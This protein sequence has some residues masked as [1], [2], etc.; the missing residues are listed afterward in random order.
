MDFVC[1]LTSWMGNKPSGQTNLIVFCS[2]GF[3]DL[4][5]ANSEGELLSELVDT[6]KMSGAKYTI[7]YASQPSGLL[8]K[9]SNLPLGRYL[10]E[11]TNT[12]AKA[13]R[14]KCDG[15]CASYHLDIR[16][17]VYDGNRYSLEV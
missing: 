13:A 14:G 5:P 8:E 2:G 3:E 17:N 16:I 1:D 9:P 7:L 10:A 4:D 15:N 6:L 12:T 11:K